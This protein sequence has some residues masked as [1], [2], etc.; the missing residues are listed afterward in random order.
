MYFLRYLWLAPEAAEKRRNGQLFSRASWGLLA[1]C[2]RI[3]GFLTTLKTFT[4]LASRFGELHFG[5]F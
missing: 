3:Q 1:E 4:T 5:P 2:T